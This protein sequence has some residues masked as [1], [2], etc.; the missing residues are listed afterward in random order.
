MPIQFKSIHYMLKS[1]AAEIR[2]KTLPK[3]GIKRCQN[4][5]IIDKM[6]KINIFVDVLLK[7]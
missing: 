1:Y 5:E 4:T 2:N 6:I 7:Y 3:Y